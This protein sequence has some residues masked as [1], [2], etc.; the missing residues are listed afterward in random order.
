MKKKAVRRLLS[1]GGVTVT[2]AGGSMLQPAITAYAG[3]TS[4]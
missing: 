1:V 2:L 4:A 3:E